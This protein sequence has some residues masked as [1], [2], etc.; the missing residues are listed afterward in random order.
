MLFEPAK[1]VD[2]LGDDSNES[3]QYFDTRDCPA[4]IARGQLQAASHTLSEGQLRTRFTQLG[5]D[6]QKIAVPSGSL[7]GGERSQYWLA[8]VL[9]ADT[10]PHLLVAGTE[11]WTPMPVDHLAA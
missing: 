4:D 5:L 11:G 8:C 10:P 7:S 6:A 3:Q 1:P 2:N 9:Y